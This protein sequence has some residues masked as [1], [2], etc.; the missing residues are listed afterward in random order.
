MNMREKVTALEL[1]LERGTKIEEL[2]TALEVKTQMLD[3]KNETI[4][5]MREELKRM[6]QLESDLH[7]L[8]GKYEKRK[9]ALN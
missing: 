9:G 6:G 5:G 1:E 3:D 4:E 7:T 2:Q 8:K